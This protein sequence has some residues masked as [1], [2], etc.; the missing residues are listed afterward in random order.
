MPAEVMHSTMWVVVLLLLC[1]LRTSRASACA[2]QFT[3]CMYGRMDRQT[4]RQHIWTVQNLA[5][6]LTVVVRECVQAL[7]SITACDGIEGCRRCCGGHGYSLLSGLPT[8]YTDYL[9]NA[10]WEG[11]NNVLCLQ[12]SPNLCPQA[13]QT[14]LISSSP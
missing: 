11:D 2:E 1:V 6:S 3:D 5:S 13:F 8:L 7:S 4:D 10:T 14:L 12:V 9:P